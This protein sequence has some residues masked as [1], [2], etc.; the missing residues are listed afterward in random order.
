MN[1][2][3]KKFLE[4]IAH[5]IIPHEKNNNVPHI[6]RAEAIL[7]MVV[8]VGVLFYFN[9]NHFKI[10]DKLNLTATVYPAVLADLANEDREN[11]GIANLTWSDTLE[12]AA[13]LKALDMAKNGYF[14]HTS[15]TGIT[16]WHWF[17]EVGYNFVYAGENLAID[18]SESENVERAWINSPTHKENIM[19]QNFTEIGIAT[20]EGIL[21]GKNTTFVVELFAKPALATTAKVAEKKIVPMIEEKGE[22]NSNV[23]GASTKNIE[24]S[25]PETKN[26]IQDVSIVEETNEFIAVKNDAIKNEIAEE[27]PSANTIAQTDVN[28]KEGVKVSTWYDRFIVN[29]TNTIKYIYLTILGAILIATVLMLTKEYRQHHKKHLVMGIALALIIIVLLCIL[30][31][32]NNPLVL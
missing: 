29:P 1:K 25:N 9:Q 30:S 3:M 5:T 14:A 4:K 6:L 24:D 15:L 8:F 19:N 18:F 16:P 31:T 2:D 12:K 32:N 21:N 11:S 23:A 22:I 17:D 10:I 28:D 27:L 7:V 20:A 26:D 13:Q